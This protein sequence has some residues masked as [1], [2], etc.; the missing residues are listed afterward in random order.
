MHAEKFSERGVIPLGTVALTIGVDTQNDGFFYLLACWGRRMEVWLPLT[1]RIT[2]DM[3]GD[4]VWKALLEILTTKWLDKD[5][6][7]YPSQISAMDVQGDFYPECLAFI[8]ANQWGTRLRAVR[9]YAPRQTQTGGQRYGILRNTYPER[10][11][12]LTVQTVDV[13]IGKSQLA[14]MLARTE[15]GAGFVHLPCNADGSDKGG[16]DVEAIA[17]LT[18]E[19]RRQ[20]NVHGYTITRWHKRPGRPNHRLDCFTYALAA[21]AISR[22][23]I[24][25]CE[26][27]RIEG[28]NVQNLVEGKKDQ[29]R[30]PFGARRMIGALELAGSEPVV[31]GM[32]GFG[33]ADQQKK[34]GFGAVPGSGVSF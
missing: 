31:G 20:T 16:W 11:T 12:G 17:E 27:Q 13:D 9:G 34:T 33:V 10:N 26:L 23:K 15:P 32:T 3:R 14:N 7:W 28:R 5:G 21:L 25:D 18:A 29:K 1:G 8:R 30:S 24:D 4:E 22:L 6:N 2:G 19:Y